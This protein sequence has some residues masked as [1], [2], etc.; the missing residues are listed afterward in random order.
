MG[1]NSQMI[2]GCPVVCS[3]LIYE[4]WYAILFGIWFDH[5]SL[6]TFS[7][8]VY[9]LH[10]NCFTSFHI[11]CFLP[12]PGRRDMQ[13]KTTWQNIVK[14]SSYTKQFLKSFPVP[15]KKTQK[16]TWRLPFLRLNMKNSAKK[17]YPL[18]SIGRSYREDFLSPMFKICFPQFVL[19]V[20]SSPWIGTYF[21]Q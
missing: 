19:L 21:I 1:H 6:S 7:W 5:K 18:N 14:A 11:T 15:E 10:V 8:V 16:K 2:V 13:F 17:Y 12:F 3:L 20:L 9:G 4:W